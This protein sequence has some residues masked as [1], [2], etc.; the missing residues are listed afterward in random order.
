MQYIKIV[1]FLLFIWVLNACQTSDDKAKVGLLFNDY[2][3]PRWERERDFFKEKMAE[4]GCEVMVDVANNDPSRQHAQALDFIAKGADVLVMTS[5]N[6]NTAATIVRAAHEAEVK[7]IAYDG[8]IYNTEL[9]YLVG[10]DLRKVGELQA[11]YVFDKMPSGNYVIFNGDKAHAASTEMNEGIMKVLN[12]PIES[13]KIKLIYNGWIENWSSANGEY[14]ANKV[15]EFANEDVNAIV[16]ANDAIAG[17][18][19]IELQKRKESKQII[20][21]GQDGELDAC[22]RI[23]N[24][25]QTMSVFKSSKLIANATAELAYK[26]AKNEK[27][28][29]LET[30]FNGRVDV[31]SLILKPI[32]VDKSNIEQTIVAEGIFTM[33]EIINYSQSDK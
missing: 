3:I 33:E 2:N 26:V 23:L 11:Q 25:Q 1:V 21:T 16:A 27:I 13:G 15:F 10:F 5:V 32:V 14:Y 19:A 24:G 6:A 22:N 30:R 8:L 18:I 12:A 31:P 9:D 29:G 28:E 17:G 4:L 7:V 20:I